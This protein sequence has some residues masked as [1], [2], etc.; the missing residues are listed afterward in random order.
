VLDAPV[1]CIVEEGFQASNLSRVALAMRGDEA[2]QRRTLAL[3][4]C[5]RVRKRCGVTTIR[6]SR[7][8]RIGPIPGAVSRIRTIL[9]LR[10]SCRR[11]ASI[12][13]FGSRKKSALQARL[14]PHR[15]A[16][17]RDGCPRALPEQRELSKRLEDRLV[18]R[19]RAELLRQAVG[20]ALVALLPPGSP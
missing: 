6:T 14:H 12:H 20:V 4:N 10:D 8:A 3:Q 16:R 15:V 19:A 11:S 17:R 2:F 13:F 18:E 5:R 7:A 1:R 9:G